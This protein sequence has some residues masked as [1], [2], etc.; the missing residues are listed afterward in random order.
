MKSI[1]IV[2][3]KYSAILLI[4]ILLL[5]WTIEW[6]PLLDLPEYI[7]HTPVKIYGLCFIAFMITIIIFSL[8]EALRKNPA[9]NIMQLILTGT[10]I[11][12]FM[13]LPFQTVLSFTY[14]N[15]KLFHFFAGTLTTT[16]AGAVISFFVAFQLKKRR[17][18]LLI[19]F[20]LVFVLLVNLLQKLLRC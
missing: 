10:A 1:V 20:I 15:D 12:F 11:C 4:W 19:I 3:A 16:L 9:L 13:E 7:P 5:W 17:T 2:V 18:D 14:N 8:K 6:S